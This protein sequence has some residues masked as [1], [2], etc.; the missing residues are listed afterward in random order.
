MRYPYW[1]CDECDTAISECSFPLTPNTEVPICPKC[2]SESV[3]IAMGDENT[4]LD[5]DTIIY[6]DEVI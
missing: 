3:D 5:L 6:T 1:I 2:G 4:E